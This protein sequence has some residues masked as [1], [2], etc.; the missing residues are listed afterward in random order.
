[1]KT[2]RAKHLFFLNY[3]QACL[4]LITAVSLLQKSLPY[5]LLASCILKTHY[6]T[7]LPVNELI[8]QMKCGT[9]VLFDSNYSLHLNNVLRVTVSTDMWR[10][11]IDCSTPR[12]WGETALYQQFSH[13]CDYINHMCVYQCMCV[14]EREGTADCEFSRNVTI[15]FPV[16]KIFH[17]D[18]F[19]Y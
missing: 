1:M 8:S 17:I 12:D 19:H 6:L 7:V 13:P 18:H 15:W 5:F 14:I 10:M 16:Q 2:L 3:T 9:V 11:L 4:T